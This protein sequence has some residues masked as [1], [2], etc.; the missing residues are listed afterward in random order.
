MLF[1]RPTRRIHNPES[2][3]LDRAGI[4]RLSDGSRLVHRG[5]GFGPVAV[6]SCCGIQV[7]GSRS[8]STPS[9]A[10]R[11]AWSMPP[12]P[13]YQ[14]LDA[15]ETADRQSDDYVGP[16]RRRRQQVRARLSTAPVR[17]GGCGTREGGDR[18]WLDRRGARRRRAALPRPLEAQLHG[19][20]ESGL[21]VL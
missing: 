7:E 6:T 1:V 13:T 16:A 19:R 10:T 12:P 9:T 5:S 4:C 20:D 2:D 8:P 21:S 11:R 15:T 3:C 17:A 14:Y 18:S